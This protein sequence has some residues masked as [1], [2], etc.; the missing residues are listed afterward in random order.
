M[1]RAGAVTFERRQGVGVDARGALRVRAREIPR[2]DPDDSLVVLD[3]RAEIAAA[4]GVAHIVEGSV[5]RSGDRL[6]V[7]AQLIRAEDG[8]HLWSENYDRTLDDIFAI[9][10]EIARKVGSALSASLLNNGGETR[11]AGVTTSDPDAYDL[12]LQARE[13]RAKYSYGGLQEAEDLL[14]GA[15]SLDGVLSAHLGPRF[16]RRKLPGPEV[17]PGGAQNQQCGP[18]RPSLT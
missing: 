5:R 15:L 6:R 8:F 16:Q 13:A 10:D 4:L 17:R 3:P 11:L 2:L 12:Y 9:Q 1:L 7:T 14:K 18:L